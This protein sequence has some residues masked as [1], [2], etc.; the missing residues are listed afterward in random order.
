[1][2][3][4][5]L[6]LVLAAGAAVAEETE[7]PVVVIS[8]TGGTS[9][10]AGTVGAEA[11]LYSESGRFRSGV[12]ALV[13]SGSSQWAGGLIGARW[14]FLGGPLSPYAGLG[15]GAF[16]ARRGT[17]DLGVQPT[18]SVEAGLSL[19]RF[20][21]GARALIP[22]TTRTQGPSAHDVAGFGD[23]ALLAQLGL[24]I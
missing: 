1:M 4:W 7:R 21:A 19:W 17:L 13:T 23:P 12:S 16:S 22:L 6:A 10:G 9:A 3:T 14:T 20:F 18:A 11:G 8:T 2:K 24:R 5:M 15:I